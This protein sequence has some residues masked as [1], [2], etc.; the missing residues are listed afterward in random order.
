MDAYKISYYI[1]NANDISSIETLSSNVSLLD[2]TATGTACTN[3]RRD[4]SWLQ[5]INGAPSTPK[6]G[7]TYLS[8]A[9]DALFTFRSNCMNCANFPSPGFG[10]S[11]ICSSW[12]FFGHQNLDVA[13]N[14]TSEQDKIGKISYMINNAMRYCLYIPNIGQK[15]GTCTGSAGSE[16]CPVHSD[17][18]FNIKAFVTSTSG[19]LKWPD[20]MVSVVSENTAIAWMKMVS[21]SSQFTENSITIVSKASTLSTTDW[22]INLDYESSYFTVTLTT[23]NDLPIGGVFFF[24]ITASCEFGL[25]FNGETNS[26]PC[27]LNNGNGDVPCILTLRQG[28]MRVEIT[29]ALLKSPNQVIIKM[30]GI[31]CRNTISAGT[32]NLE[33]KSYLSKAMNPLKLIDKSSTQIVLTYNAAAASGS[34]GITLPNIVADHYQ[35]TGKAFVNMEVSITGRPF[36]YL[37]DNTQFTLGSGAYDTSYAGKVYCSLQEKSTGH[38][39]TEF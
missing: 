26:P 22:I 17:P 23:Q 29:Q 18:G 15:T 36:V 13:N 19:G 24:G 8:G 14:P 32:C 11:L 33:V 16:N 9:P 6:V 1:P 25:T 37:C 30:Y 35:S 27:Y 3:C 7:E 39:L 5:V 2:A 28:G 20:D 21:L 38:L 34:G 4:N 12:E 10:T 31:S